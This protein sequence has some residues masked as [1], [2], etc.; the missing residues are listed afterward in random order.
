MVT[1]SP[2]VKGCRG[3]K[4]VPALPG[5]TVSFPLC[6][7]LFDPVTTGLPERSDG[8]REEKIICDCPEAS[9]VFGNGIT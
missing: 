3:A 4:T 2:A 9:G 8:F 1:V 6:R 7:P 5:R